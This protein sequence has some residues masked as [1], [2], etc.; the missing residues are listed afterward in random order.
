MNETEH[1][2]RNLA[3]VRPED[4]IKPRIKKLNVRWICFD[5]THSGIADTPLEAYAMYIALRYGP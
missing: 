3:R 1:L 5:E 4:Y 2:M